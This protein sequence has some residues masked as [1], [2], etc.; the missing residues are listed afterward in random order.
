MLYYF[1]VIFRTPATSL[2]PTD[3]V[4]AIHVPTAQCARKLATLGNL[5]LTAHAQM[6]TTL[7]L[8]ANEK[9]TVVLTTSGM[10]RQ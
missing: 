1:F 8:Y 2:T 6:N 9:S 10:T 3:V 4:A 5:A 7:A